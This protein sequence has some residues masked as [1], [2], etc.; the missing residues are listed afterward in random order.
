[1]AHHADGQRWLDGDGQRSRTH[2]PA[3]R[4]HRFNPDGD[5]RHQCLHVVAVDQ[6]GNLWHTVRMANGSWPFPFGNVTAQL[7][8]PSVGAT[9]QARCAATP[10]GDLHVLA[11]DKSDGMWH[12]MRLANGDWPF[13]FGD[14]QAA[15]P[16]M[17][18]LPESD[19]A[20]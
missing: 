6:N 18:R 10:K 9:P 14:V 2:H 19:P 17:R 8:G 15:V 5:V 4:Q 12:T 20:R 3:R 13:A 16:R 1:V 7:I 11:I